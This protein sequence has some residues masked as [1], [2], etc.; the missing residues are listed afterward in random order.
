MTNRACQEFSDE[1]KLYLTFET[2]DL[3]PAFLRVV[4]GVPLE[5]LDAMEKGFRSVRS[6][7]VRTA[8]LFVLA[9]KMKRQIS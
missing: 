5:E 8:T 2:F 9:E 3:A 6:K 4:E 1:L 7:P